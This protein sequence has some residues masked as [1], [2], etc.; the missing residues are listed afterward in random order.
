MRLK[1]R[2]AVLKEPR[3]CRLCGR[4]VKNGYI[5]KG[6]I[7]GCACEDCYGRVYGPLSEKLAFHAGDIFTRAF[8]RPLHIEEGVVMFPGL[9]AARMNTFNYGLRRVLPVLLIVAFL[10]SG[11][12]IAMVQRIPGHFVYICEQAVALVKG[13][14]IHLWQAVLHL[15]PVLGHLR[16][17]LLLIAA[18]VWRM[19]MQSIDWIGSILG[20][21]HV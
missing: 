3:P 9:S 13:A 1:C 6:V 15:L 11:D 18:A 8:W 7:K 16:E 21:F 17:A 2:P 14:G 4:P 12:S 10:A 5:L 19:I 20:G